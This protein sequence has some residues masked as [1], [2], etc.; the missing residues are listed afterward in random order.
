[1]VQV[2]RVSTRYTELVQV[3]LYRVSTRYMELVQVRRVSTRYTE[4]VQ[5]YRVST[6]YIMFTECCKVYDPLKSH[7]SHE[8]CVKF[9]VLRY[10]SSADFTGS[11]PI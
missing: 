7:H 1:M 3:G 2:R 8:S 5:V 4:L 9:L 10:V 11:F 6:R